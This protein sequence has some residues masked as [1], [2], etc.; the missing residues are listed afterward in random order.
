MVLRSSNLKPFQKQK[1]DPI[2]LKEFKTF[3]KHLA[4]VACAAKAPIR[5]KLLDESIARVN[6]AGDAENIGRWCW[7]TPTQFS[8]LEQADKLSRVILIGGNGTGKTVMLDAFA[9][10]SAKEHPDTPV[11]FGIHT[12]ISNQRQVTEDCIAII[13]CSILI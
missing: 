7:W 13:P 1:I 4:F 11:V 6:K 2:T 10:K 8:L 9:T 5:Q 12:I 3:F